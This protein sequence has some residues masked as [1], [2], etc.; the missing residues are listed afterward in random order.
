MK[1]LSELSTEELLD[2]IYDNSTLYERFCE[3]VE[4]D[5]MFWVNEK[6]EFL[7]DSLKDWSIG[8]Y[9]SNYIE[10]RNYYDFVNSVSDYK[11]T[12]GLS[13]G[14][15]KLLSHCLKLRGTNLFEYH[16][17]RLKDEILKSEFDGETDIDFNDKE[18]MIDYL[19]V[20]ADSFNDYKVDDD[21]NIIEQ[22]IVGQVA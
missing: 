12:F 2:V 10:V 18:S 6:L 5:V 22:H 11:N 3:I 16:A 20:F 21:G 4:E 9:Y 14:T 15:V 1:N 17:E 19:D 8:L 13:Y 7:K